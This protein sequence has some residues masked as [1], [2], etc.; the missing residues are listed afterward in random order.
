M[1]ARLALATFAA[2]ALVVAA[3]P[4]RAVTVGYVEHWPGTDEAGWDSGSDH[5]NPGTGG[6]LGVG[7][8]FERVARSFAAQLG[9]RSTSAHYAGNW[10]NAGA[11]RVRLALNDIETNEALS[12]HVSLGNSTNFWQCN[13]GFVPPENAWGTFEVDLTDSSQF[14]RIIGTDSYADALQNADRILVRHDLPPFVQSPNGLAGQFGL[15]QVEILGPGWVGVGDGPL[16]AQP[17]WLAPPSPNPS[18]GAVACA[19]ETNAA[20][21]LRFSVL[22]ARGRVVR[23][24][25]LEA[26]SAGRKLWVWDGLDASGA[27]VAAGVYVVRVVGAGGGTSRNIVRVD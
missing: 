27:R 23:T 24:A 15:D 5:S 12:I 13:V 19:V 7:D 2:L 4:S 11:S 1:N 3:D 20:G 25:S 8:G 10:L 22:D 16:A 6:T 26:S 21:T 14:T 17:V 9:I 18:R